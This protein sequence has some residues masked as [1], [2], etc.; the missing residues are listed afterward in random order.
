MIKNVKL[1]D[2]FKLPENH[3]RATITLLQVA[4]GKPNFK[5]N[6]KKHGVTNSIT[7]LTFGEVIRLKSLITGGNI[8]NVIEAVRLVYKS[9]PLEMPVVRFYQCANFI[10]KDVKNIIEV[11]QERYKTLPTPHDDKLQQ[12][13]A[14]EL[15]IFGDLPVIDSLAGGDILK[16]K[17]IE[18]LP[19][20]T[21]H[22]TLWHRAVKENIN[23]R[24]QEL[25]K[26][27]T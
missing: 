3:Q 10:I 25:T 19:Y 11:E 22:F 14:E 5:H 12:A 16:Y 6:N 21:V 24:F 15:A 27:P 20:M 9:N 8:E 13:G 1:K 18:K 23:I 7:E 2:F 4:K 17:Q 26:Q